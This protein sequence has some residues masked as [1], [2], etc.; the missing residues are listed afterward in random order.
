MKFKIK[1]KVK[2]S[3]NS[4]Y[5]YQAKEF[6][7]TITKIT[8][9][10]LPYDVTFINNYKNSYGDKDLELITKNKNM[11]KQIGFSNW[12]KTY[13]NLNIEST[14]NNL[15]D[16]KYRLSEANKLLKT[17][18]SDHKKL[19]ELKLK[20][21]LGINILGQ[22]ANSIISRTDDKNY[23]QSN[24]KRYNNIIAKTKE[25]KLTPKEIEQTFKELKNN[26][27]ITNIITNEDYIFITTKSLKN[28]EKETLGRFFIRIDK[29]LNPNIYIKNMDYQTEHEEPYDHYHIRD[30]HPCLD[31]YKDI[32]TKYSET[33]NLYFVID[34]I[35]TFIKEGDNPHSYYINK[36]DW[37]EKRIKNNI[38]IHNLI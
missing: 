2:L 21:S 16:T 22:Y 3:K 24:I 29:E 28:K 19:E 38:N 26:K 10:H 13:F 30:G 27:N 12:L 23:Y 18:N 33:R 35:I 8:N 25:K 6:K 9:E 31:E 32:I 36:D 4:E 7:G 20:H 34:T 17:L 1:D 15:Q 11:P 37:F 14:K 5:Y